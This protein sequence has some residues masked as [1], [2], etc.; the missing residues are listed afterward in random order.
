[1][2]NM[3]KIMAAMLALLMIGS[4][5][6]CGSANDP[7]TGNQ[8]QQ[9]GGQKYTLTIWGAEQDQD[10]LKAMCN[11]YAAANPQNTYKF[12]FGVQGENDAADK[13]LND[14]TSGPDIYSFP[15]DQINRLY[16]GGALA[17]IGGN[18][19]TEVKAANTADSID[20]ATITVNGVDQLMAY[21]STGDNCYFV[22]Y[23]KSVFTNPEDLTSLDRMLDVAEAAGK[24][25]HFKLNDDGWYLSSFFFSNPELKYNV[26][27]N[28]NMVEESVEINYDD[29]AGMEVMKS[30]RAYLQRDGLVATTDD[31]KII[32]G[33][34]PN[35]EGKT[36]IAAAITGI[37]NKEKIQEQLGDNMGVCVLPTAN[38]GGQQI[39]LSGYFGYKLIGVNGYSKNKGEAHKL[40][41]WLT[42][43]QNQILRYE[44]RGF[45]PTNINAMKLEKIVND[46]V[47][48]TIFQQAAFNR[49]QK[50]VP[51]QYWTP[52]GSL[53][54]PI[55]TAKE[56]GT[57]VTDAMLQEYLDA[58]CN[59]IRKKAE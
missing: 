49:T 56:N 28:E 36:T 4:M 18:I 17:R 54:T 42:N 12:L 25:V 3:K 55:I 20:A 31:S 43:E 1:M 15:S 39:Q 48:N 16:A 29:P 40:A 45:G 9:G 59:Q 32:A 23:D 19:E 13:I 46:P 44:T 38:I 37:W 57:E 7:T 52:M 26:T 8:Q 14:V 11:A 58:L 33:F 6:A 41:Q 53:I 34:T 21:P 10:M 35:A 50:G 24:T 2:K 27:Y 47:I 30:L 5:V 22:Y 51:S